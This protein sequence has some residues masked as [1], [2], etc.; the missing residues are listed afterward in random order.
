VI[1]GGAKL[2]V[3]QTDD[4]MLLPAPGDPVPD[5]FERCSICHGEGSDIKDV[6]VVHA[7]WF[8]LQ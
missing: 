6:G 1:P 4:G 2:S 5:A 8:P 3:K 7:P